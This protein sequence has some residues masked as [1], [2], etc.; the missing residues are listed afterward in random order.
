[1]KVSIRKE[2]PADR[3]AVFEVH[4]AAFETPAEARAVDGV[5]ANAEPVISLVAVADDRV[6]G[7]V[8]FS[9]VTLP[10]G[11]DGGRAMGLAPLAVLPEFQNRGIGSRL[12]RAGLEACRHIGR[13]VVFVLGHAE[14]YPRFGF[15]SAAQHGFTFMGAENRHFMVVGL[16]SK[17]L[18]G[19]SGDVRYRPEFDGT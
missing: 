19:M 8:L 1:V 7:H 12:A 4:A 3:E 5:R 6:V 13:D 14:Y 15:E 10:G 18:V 17:A 16:R 11:A 9:P 2:K